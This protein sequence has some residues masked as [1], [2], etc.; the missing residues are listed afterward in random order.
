[1]GANKNWMR[2]LSNSEYPDKKH[3]IITSWKRD[4]VSEYFL[5]SWNE[6]GLPVA[7]KTLVKTVSLCGV[8][9][10]ILK[11]YEYL[12]LLAAATNTELWSRER[13]FRWL[14]REFEFRY[15]K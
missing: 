9:N 15:I 4:Y 8:S 12:L 6:K 14:I 2:V 1:M 3:L 7:E 13:R 11:P 10:F 5:A